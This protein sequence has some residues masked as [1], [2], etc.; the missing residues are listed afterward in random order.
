ML[1][2]GGISLSLSGL[3]CYPMQDGMFATL[4]GVMLLY[5]AQVDICSLGKV[6]GHFLPILLS[7][8]LLVEVASFGLGLGKASKLSHVSGGFCLQSKI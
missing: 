3:M 7:E 1:D 2:L 5:P 8:R 6:T 4:P